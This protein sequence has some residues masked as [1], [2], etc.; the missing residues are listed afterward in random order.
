MTLGL[1]DE[2]CPV[3]L[4]T[5]GALYRADEEQ[6]AEMLAGLPETTRAQLAVYLYGRSHTHELGIRIAAG[7][8]VSTLR[9]AAGLIGNVLYEQSRKG[10]VAPIYG[11]YRS[12]AK[13]KISL[14][15]AK[16][17]VWSAA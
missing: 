15:G 16:P 6:L 2:A 9:R 5:L 17:T 10:Y 14:G 11:G 13:A 4:E 8:E 12:V 1:L 3:S 7:C